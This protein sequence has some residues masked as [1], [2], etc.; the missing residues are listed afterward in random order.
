M[1]RRRAA[2]PE[3]ERSGSGGVRRDGL[4]AVLVGLAVNEL[5]LE[6]TVVPDG[7]IGSTSIRLAVAA[8][9]AL[10]IGVGLFVLIRRPGFR[11]PWKRIGIAGG[12]AL[13]A[14]FAC[15]AVVDLFAPG[16]AAGVPGLDYFDY[17]ARFRP[18]SALV[19]VP[20]ETGRSLEYRLAG[21]LAGADDG[22]PPLEV[23]YR[24]SY[25]D[26]GFR[27]N[28]GSPPW[29]AVVIGDS[30]VEFGENDST[31]VSE[32]L[33]RASGLST[34]NLGRG[35][36][37]P[38]QYVELFRRHG[39]DLDPRFAILCFFEGN[40]PENVVA[41]LRW[42]A[43]G[44]YDEFS[45]VEGTLFQRFVNLNYEVLSEIQ[46]GLSRT[47]GEPSGDAGERR[48]GGRETLEIAVDGERSRMRFA[49]W[50]DPT[51]DPDELLRQERW[52][53]VDD[54][55]AE[56]RRLAAGD[57]IVPIV[58]FIP[59]KISVYR[60]FVVGDE[61]PPLE[62]DDADAPARRATPPRGRAL[63]T[64]AR[65]ND[66]EFV[67]LTLT[68]RRHAAD[69][70]LVYYRQDTHWSPRGR[71]I[72]ADTLADLLGQRAPTPPPSRD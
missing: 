53:A 64:L 33:R 21:D 43:G 54:L 17:R 30:F 61:G 62:S 5:T 44:S 52:R 39:P 57:D 15:F 25:N 27:R 69:G 38:H 55:L 24:A 42:K 66:I 48:A 8:F 60:P 9:Q 47:P 28:G 7:E 23:P 19:M 2:E 32:M 31:T 70:A 58:T 71:R 63:A 36:Y 40:D 13:V 49:Y 16:L 51:R 10:M 6:W 14:W 46:A 67:D 68:F 34:F 59:A 11:L 12:S 65:R 20:R 56:F 3:R 4:A 22:L 35:W 41:Y 45:L 1:T 50:P 29:D 72:A 37:G 18:D 26:R